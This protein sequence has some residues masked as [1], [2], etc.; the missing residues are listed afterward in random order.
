MAARPKLI[1]LSHI[2]TEARAVGAVLVQPIDSDSVNL[3]KVKT[4]SGDFRNQTIDLSH[5]KSEP[6]AALPSEDCLNQ[7]DD[8]GSSDRD[9]EDGVGV[10][11]RIRPNSSFLRRYVGGVEKSNEKLPIVSPA[12]EGSAIVST[13]KASVIQE[14]K[15][16]RER[17]LG[18]LR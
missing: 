10:N 11:G 6:L 8:Q 3:E 12:I 16:L 7:N 4:P 5:V 1:N 18:S 13:D 2:K 14:L 9:E 17:G 15:G